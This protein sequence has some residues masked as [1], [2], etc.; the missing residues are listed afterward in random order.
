MDH[1]ELVALL[2]VG[3]LT[4]YQVKSD[5]RALCSLMMVKVHQSKRAL[6]GH[7]MRRE[8]SFDI[9]FDSR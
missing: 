1:A 8:H 3:N 2:F 7:L 6:E 9:L 4:P 5:P